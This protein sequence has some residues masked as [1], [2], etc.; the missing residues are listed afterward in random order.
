[1]IEKITS[2]DHNID[3]ESASADESME[4]LEEAASLHISLLNPLM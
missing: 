3:A 4:D 2:A 1:V